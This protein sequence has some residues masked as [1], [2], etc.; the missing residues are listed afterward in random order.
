MTVAWAALYSLATLGLVAYGLHAAY[1]LALARRRG[2]AHVA[3]LAA[4]RAASRVGRS[5]YPRV[6]VQLPVYNEPRVVARLIDA[7]CALD[8]PREALAVQV[9]DDSTD[10]TTDLARAAVEA[11]R[12]RGVDA[13][14][15]H[16]AQ[17]AGYKA[18]ALAHGLTLSDAP[19]VAVFDADFVP[20]PDFLRSALPLFEAGPRVACV[21]G[22]WTHL[23]RE[24][25]FL[26]R[27][28]AV[29]IDA[30]FCVQQ[31]ARASGAG[32]VNFNG[33]AGIWRRAAI[34]DAGGWSAAT[35][36]EDLDLSFRAHLRGWQLVFDPTLTA[37]AELPTTLAENVRLRRELRQAQEDLA[38]LKQAA[39]F[40][41]RESK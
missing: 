21:Q 39:R 5:E 3:R 36:T 13:S 10:E 22:R 4:C 14:F 33:S 41:A 19:Y 35:L 38:I 12:A 7:V 18:G 23:N 34:D 11:A 40:F 6:L 1:L 2:P 8:W 32:L 31:L 24:Q 25:S 17:R 27:A 30:H 37:P 26:T 15:V 16:R 28:Q 20:T 29:A 9:L